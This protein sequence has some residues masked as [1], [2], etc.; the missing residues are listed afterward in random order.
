MNLIITMAGK[1]L[2]FKNAG[3]TTPKYLLKLSNGDSILKEVLKRLIGNYKFEKTVLIAN[4]ADVEFREQ[5]HKTLKTSN[6]DE[7]EILFTRDTR[8]QAETALLAIEALEKSSCKSQKILIHNIDTVLIDRD[9]SR[10]SQLLDEYDGYIDVFEATGKN[11]SYVKTDET[12][13]IVDIKEKEVISNKATTGLYGFRNMKEFKDYYK[14]LQTSREHYISFIYEMMIQD[15][16]R[17]VVNQKYA[18]TVILG[19][20]EEYETYKN[21]F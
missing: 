11:Y 17:I 21:I 2:R 18:P 14:R 4:N 1:Y 3:Y 19:T 13:V 16:K 6:A 8:G 15:K 9:I 12:N 7:Y 10:I 5:I 20:P